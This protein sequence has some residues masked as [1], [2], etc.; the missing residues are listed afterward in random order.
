MKQFPLK[1]TPKNRHLFTQMK[2]NLLLENWREKILNYILNNQKDGLDLYDENNNIIDKRIIECLRF[3]L[4]NLGWTT[5]LAY[6]GT[7]IFIYDK[8]N[9]IQEYKHS[10]CEEL[11]E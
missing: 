5:S 3:E 2:F 1:L 10:L 6:N 11:F 7:I 8:D 9:E 4:K